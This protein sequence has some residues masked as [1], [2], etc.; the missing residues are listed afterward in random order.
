MS[1]A[2]L[3]QRVAELRAEVR[4]LG[5]LGDLS[6]A[7]PVHEEIRQLAEQIGDP[8]LIELSICNL[9]TASIYEGGGADYLPRLRSI[10]TETRSDENAFLAAYSISRY[11]E[12]V[13]EHKKFLYY[14]RIALQRAG[15][16]GK[17]EWLLN[18]RNHLGNALLAVSQIGDA[19]REYS[20]A[21]HEADPDN[22]T[23]VTLTY[24]LGYCRLLQHRAEEGIAL[25]VRGL[26]GAV[27][28][29][30]RRAEAQVRLDLGFACLERGA[31][32]QAGRQIR[33]A[34]AMAEDLGWVDGI[35][36]ALYLLGE[37]QRL[38]GSVEEA[39]SSFS[40]LQKTYYP[41]Q[42]YLGT[43]LMAVDVRRMLNLHA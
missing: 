34:L 9:G 15:T 8:V 37:S 25:L 5:E 10:L 3:R 21:L 26:R 19:A 20:N 36:N 33:R 1:E 29:G 31:L 42:P 39:E 6:A 30:A 12:N 4:R 43:L 2:L 27:R 23:G 18:A 40:R 41:E 35:K 28:L 22:I 17:L 38:E 16:A 13:K 14:A 7:R 11:Y 24:N 32:R